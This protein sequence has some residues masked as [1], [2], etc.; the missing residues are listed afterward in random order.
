MYFS[1]T[2]KKK[3]FRNVALFQNNRIIGIQSRM[4]IERK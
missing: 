1:V 3:K 4:I 2:K